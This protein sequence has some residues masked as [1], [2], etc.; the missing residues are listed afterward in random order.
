MGVE[1]GRKDERKM[2]R[3]ERKGRKSSFNRSENLE[4]MGRER[5]ERHEGRRWRIGR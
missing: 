5:E 4:E 3:E 2:M 1:D